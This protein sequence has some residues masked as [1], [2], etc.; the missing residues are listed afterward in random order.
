LAWEKLKE[1]EK[2]YLAGLLDGEGTICVSKHKSS[3]IR[4][5]IAIYNTHFETMEWV[6]KCFEHENQKR[7]I[8]KRRDDRHTKN[9]YHIYFRS[10]PEIR[11]II[12]LLLPY[13]KIKKEQ[14]ELMLEFIDYVKNRESYHYTEENKNKLLE[15]KTKFNILN[16]GVK[17]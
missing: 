3:I 17:K 4:P 8:D 9:N 2:A 13:L 7:S 14:A 5:T 1:T 6:A 15:F 11:R 16:K 12:E 10:F